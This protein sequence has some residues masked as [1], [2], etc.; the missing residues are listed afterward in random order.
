MYY[1]LIKIIN[2]NALPKGKHI[3]YFFCLTTILTPNFTKKIGKQHFCRLPTPY[4][5][6]QLPAKVQYLV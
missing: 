2:G 1:K 6:L 5:V 3:C 4:L